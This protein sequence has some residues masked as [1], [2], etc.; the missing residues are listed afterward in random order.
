[1]EQPCARATGT[2]VAVHDLARS[3]LSS[4]VPAH[5]HPYSS[6]PVPFA[7]F[8]AAFPPRMV[9]NSPYSPLSV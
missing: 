2:L 6:T 8:L 7:T 4:S 5:P 1:M 3:S 9:S